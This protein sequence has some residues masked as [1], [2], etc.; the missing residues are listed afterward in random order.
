M[1]TPASTHDDM[2]EVP[3]GA[4]L[5]GLAKHI[6]ASCG[7]CSR[8]FMRCKKEDM[9]PKAC[10]DKGATLTRCVMDVTKTANEKAGEELNK[11][12]SCLHYYGSKFEK[13]RKEQ[14]AFD[15]AMARA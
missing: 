6:K 14:A 5:Y 12:A 8:D 7:T 10:L 13:C 9:D 11:F 4:V 2:A 15:E 3:T 1:T